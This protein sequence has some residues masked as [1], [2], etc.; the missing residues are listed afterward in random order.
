M[1]EP[2]NRWIVKRNCSAS[3]RQLA[4]VFASMVLLSLAIGIG[5]ARLGL[6]LTLPFVGVELIA[7]AV[8]FICY[9][10][11]AANFE[12]IELAGGTLRIEQVCGARHSAWQFRAHG[13]RIEATDA[14]GGASGARL[15]VVDRAERIEI[16][17]HLV[18][19]RRRE[20]GSELR[21]A[22]RSA[23]AATA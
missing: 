17:T 8:A 1:P 19:R 6:W 20:L 15:F 5:F 16:G 18:D 3:P 7:L 12:V 4:L 13:A 21:H 14:A 10:R 23:A 9:A 2:R 11:H 22:L